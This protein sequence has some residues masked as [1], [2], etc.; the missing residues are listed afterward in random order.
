MYDGEWFND[1][2]HGYGIES[3]NYNRIKYK[4]DFDEGKKSGMGRFEFEGGYYEGEFQDG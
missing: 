1:Q 4:G 3:W 2:Q